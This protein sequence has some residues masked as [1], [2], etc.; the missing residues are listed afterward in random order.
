MA[1]IGDV[2]NASVPAFYNGP[3]RDPWEHSGNR[4]GL[5][6]DCKRSRSVK[7]GLPPGCG[8]S[9]GNGWG[10]ASLHLCLMLRYSVPADLLCS[11]G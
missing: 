1:Q 7:V 8:S 6:L 3:K 5:K 4:D 2:C 10:A 9:L 11:A